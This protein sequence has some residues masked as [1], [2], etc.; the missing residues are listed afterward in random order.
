MPALAWRTAERQCG[1]VSVGAA[2]VCS[3]DR[4]RA[5]RRIVN[6]VGETAQ[7][8]SD[9]ASVGAAKHLSGSVAASW[10]AVTP[11]IRLHRSRT[12]NEPGRARTCDSQSS[13]RR[14]VLR[15][16]ISMCARLA[17][18]R[19]TII[20]GIARRCVQD[21]P[22]TCCARG[23]RL[24]VPR[25]TASKLTS[26]ASHCVTQLRLDPWHALFLRADKI[27]PSHGQPSRAT[28][29]TICRQR[30]ELDD[31]SRRVRLCCV[32]RLLANRY[33]SA[34]VCD[35]CVASSSSPL[36]PV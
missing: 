3:V 34:V 9:C 20:A 5:R 31:A 26:H 4:R 36:G 24:A 15:G 1:R 10:C 18:F 17:G 22:R 13:A 32:V 23:H 28:L 12:S 2:R 14:T 30:S 21:G 27:R 19:R 16:C 6:A 25:P 7:T 8:L 33:F 29:Q 35:F 11:P